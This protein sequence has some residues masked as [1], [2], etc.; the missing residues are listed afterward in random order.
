VPPTEAVTVTDPAHP[1]YGLT[2]PCLGVTN[3]QRL[4]RACV[5]WLA[6][7]IERLVPVAATSL[8]PIAHPAPRCR[9]AP[10]VSPPSCAC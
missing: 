1:L 9:L 2:L 10:R 6:P 8:S 5:V 4:G 3:K 7:G